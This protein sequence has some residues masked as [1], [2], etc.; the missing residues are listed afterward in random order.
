MANKQNITEEKIFQY[1]INEM[2]KQKSIYFDSVNELDM[3]KMSEDAIDHF[4]VDTP[5]GDSDIESKIFEWA[6]EFSDDYY[7]YPNVNKF[8]N[9]KLQN[10]V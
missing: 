5:N 6:I 2:L 4:K 9:C 10:Y 3:T 1:W 7:T 8:L